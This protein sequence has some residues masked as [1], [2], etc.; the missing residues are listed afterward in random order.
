MELNSITVKKFKKI[1]K[2]KINLADLNI[3]VGA[4]G[5]GKSSALQAI[6]LASCLMR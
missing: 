6:H 3:L 1:K 5:S 2:A 4:N